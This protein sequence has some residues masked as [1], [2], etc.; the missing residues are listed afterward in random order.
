M[1]RSLLIGAGGLI[2]AAL[3]TIW[4]LWWSPGPKRGPHDIIVPE[5]SSL[6]SVS[7]E[8]AK[9][10]AIPGTSKTYYVMARIFGSHDPVQAGEF[11]IPR[12]MGGAAILDL[13]QHGKPVQRDRK[14]VV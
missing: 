3:L 14:S 12:G 13:L 4:F 5:G 11:Q 8:L 6:R 9:Q 7:R 2:L 1:R 10:G